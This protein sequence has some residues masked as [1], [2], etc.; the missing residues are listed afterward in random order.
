MARFALEAVTA[1]D[2]DDPCRRSNHYRIDATSSAT[3]AQVW[4]E[5]H[6]RRPLHWCSSLRACEW[7]PGSPKGVG[8]T[9]R[10]SMAPGVWV[11]E[12]YFLWQEEPDHLEC[13]F[14]VTECTVPGIRRFGSAIA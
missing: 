11:Y 7:S 6:G 12:S 9:R 14:T 13:A 5:L 8:S 1:G 10:M 2:F 4:E 3:P